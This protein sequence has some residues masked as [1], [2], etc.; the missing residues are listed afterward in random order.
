MSPQAPEPAGGWFGAKPVDEVQV[1]L[2]AAVASLSAELDA[3]RSL[4]WLILNDR[5]GGSVEL[6]PEQIDALPHD[7]SIRV[8]ITPAGVVTLEAVLS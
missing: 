1:S 7:S 6:H 4:V 2:E 5:L 8:T 3:L